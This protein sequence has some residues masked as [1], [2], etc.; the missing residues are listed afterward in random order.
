MN[1]VMDDNKMLT[2]VS[3]ERIPLTKEMR[4]L[5]EIHNLDHASPATVSRAGMVFVNDRDVKWTS[6]VSGCVTLFGAVQSAPQL[7]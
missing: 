2:L 1:S 5:F 4:L 3:N 7:F 6:L